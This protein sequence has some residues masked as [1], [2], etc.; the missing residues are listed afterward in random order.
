MPIIFNWP[1]TASVGNDWPSDFIDKAFA[2]IEGLPI[3]PRI[4]VQMTIIDTD[5][6]GLTPQDV[7]SGINLLAHDIEAQACRC[8]WPETQA[9]R[10]RLAILRAGEEEMQR[11]RIDDERERTCRIGV[12]GRPYEPET[13]A[14]HPSPPPDRA[15]RPKVALVSPP[16]PD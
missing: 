16:D 1:I 13:D 9:D 8:G 3:S 7:N 2:T 15:I 11:L 14:P 12:I 6:D 4:L 5:F 10:L